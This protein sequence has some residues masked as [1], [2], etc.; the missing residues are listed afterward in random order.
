MEVHVSSAWPVMYASRTNGHRNGSGHRN[1]RNRLSF[2]DLAGDDLGN[3]GVYKDM[4]FNYFMKGPLG[5]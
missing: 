3:F 5:P 4:L 2:R 1:R